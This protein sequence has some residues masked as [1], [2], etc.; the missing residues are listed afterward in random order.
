[1]ESISTIA[2]GR[3]FFEQHG[4][5]YSST[6]IRARR[7]GRVD[8]DVPLMG[9]PAYSRARALAVQLRETMPK[10][11]FQSLC[12]YNAESNA[13]LK[14][15]QAAGEKLDLSK[16]KMYPCVVP[17]RGVSQE[18]MR[19]AIKTLQDLVARNRP[20]RKKRWWKFW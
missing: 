12:A 4:V 8:L 9:I 10:E 15:I 14:A 5:Q 18:T 1:V 16:M 2:F 19:L 7:D 17:D 3:A 20:A 11:A 13:I 6:V